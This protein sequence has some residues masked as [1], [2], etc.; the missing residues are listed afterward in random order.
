MN[1]LV[2]FGLWS[3]EKCDSKIFTWKNELTESDPEAE[4]DGEA[5]GGLLRNTDAKAMSEGIVE[6]VIATS[7]GLILVSRE[8]KNRRITEVRLECG[9]KCCAIN[10]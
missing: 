4:Y 10:L 6:S 8:R 9:K 7:A 1:K 5:L 3:L 2:E